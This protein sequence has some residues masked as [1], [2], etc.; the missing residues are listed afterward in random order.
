MV[1]Y[2]AQRAAAPAQPRRPL[3][4]RLLQ[5]LVRRDGS[6]RARHHLSQLEP[7]MLR[8]IGLTPEEAQALS[9]A[10]EWDAPAHWKR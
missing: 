7:H 2:A 6:A 9:Q 4:L 8:D 10:P 5:L 3:W 1:S